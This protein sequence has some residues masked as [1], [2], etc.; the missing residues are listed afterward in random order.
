MSISKRD[1]ILHVSRFI[2]DRVAN[3]T[4]QD[5]KTA[6][7]RSITLSEASHSRLSIGEPGQMDTLHF[8]SACRYP[9]IPEDHVEIK[10]KAVGVNAKVMILFLLKKFSPNPFPGS[11]HFVWED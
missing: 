6:H 9:S 7:T 8:V 1:G 3:Q 2:A 5:K 11:I 10:V 4:F